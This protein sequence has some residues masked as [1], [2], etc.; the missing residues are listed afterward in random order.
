M[1]KY[2]DYSRG[3]ADGIQWAC[4]LAKKEGIEALEKEARLRAVTGIKPIGRFE[5]DLD[6]RVD[7]IIAHCM[8]RVL[9]ISVAVLHDT[10]GFGPT[11]MMRFFDTFSEATHLLMAGRH[12]GALWTDFSSEIEKTYGVTISANTEGVIIREASNG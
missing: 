11:R 8:K 6:A 9:I 10:F 7:S 4:D 12:N 5:E 1:R 2:N 3:R